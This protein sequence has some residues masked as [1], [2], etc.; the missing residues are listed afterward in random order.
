MNMR[1][2]PRVLLSILVLLAACAACQ[3]ASLPDTLSGRWQVAEVHINTYASA[4]TNY[5]WNDPRLR[6]RIFTFDDTQISNDTAD[7]SRCER[8]QATVA[9]M[10]P[11]RL[12]D[13]SLAHTA[14]DDSDPE[15]HPSPAAYVLKIDPNEPVNVISIHCKDGLWEGD[16]GTGKG[17]EGAWMFFTHAGQLVMRWRDETIL[18]LNRLPLDAKPQ[19]SFDCA[20]ASS[21]TEKAICG[22][23]Q[24]A[25]FDRSV[26]ESYKIAHD[27]IKRNG[28]N[29]SSLVS[30]QQAW[31]RKRNA[32]GSDASCLLTAMKQR[33]EELSNY[34]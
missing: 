31:L 10:S 28:D 15:T 29:L 14:G 3:A 27:D 8:P 23:I 5:G 26:S 25:S 21:T 11:T 4:K 7:G 17:L 16:L 33:L 20:K 19:T 13:G 6:G 12:M 32:C 34:P 9:N 1:H 18:V 30:S 22:S 2:L 24:L